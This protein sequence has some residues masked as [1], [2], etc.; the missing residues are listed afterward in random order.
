MSVFKK[1]RT[2]SNSGEYISE[3]ISS[4]KE[5]YSIKKEYD[6]ILVSINE[7][8]IFDYANKNKNDLQDYVEYFELNEK[9][10]RGCS[11]CHE[12]PNHFVIADFVPTEDEYILVAFYKDIEVFRQAFNK[13]DGFYSVGTYYLKS[14]MNGYYLSS[15]TVKDDEQPIFNANIFDQIQKDINGFFSKKEFYEKQ[16]IPFRRGILLYGPPGTGK[17]SLIRYLFKQ[18]PDKFGIVFDCNKHIDREISSFLKIATGEHQTILA[19]EDIDG[20]D[21][22]D[23]SDFLNLLDGINGIENCFIVATTNHVHKI[24]EA[25][26]S[27]PSR[28][29]RLYHIDLPSDNARKE[30]LLRYFPDLTENELTTYVRKTEGFSGAYFKE[31]FVFKNIQDCTLEEAINSLREQINIF[32]KEVKQDYMG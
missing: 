2:E 28:F 19:I 24:D 18:N 12:T 16:N 8:V 22:Y 6:K 4:Y 31:I 15:T 32:N 5:K 3:L 23:R 7:S 13:K 10:L 30:L 21:T 25:L 14:S 27:R 29:D 9:E 1:L 11:F 17:T 26:V 20:I